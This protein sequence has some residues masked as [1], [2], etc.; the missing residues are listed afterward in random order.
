MSRWRPLERW[1]LTEHRRLESN[2]VRSR[3]DPELV[4]EHTT[5]AAH[6][7]QSI[8][9][10]AGPVERQHELRPEP[11]TKG[12]LT[13]QRLELGG[14]DHVLTERQAGV[15]EILDRTEPEILEARRLG[16]RP[17]CLPELGERRS[18]PT[19]ERSAEPASD[20]IRVRLIRPGDLVQRLLEAECVE[21]IGANVEHV[22]AVRRAHG[23]RTDR[24]S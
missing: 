9:L 10:A 1:L 5:Q 12:M 15:D 13:D 21:P 18:A 6:G 11:L 7:V 19:L 23:L 20:P 22:A 17:S 24:P 14:Q 16:H 3:L 2:D 8:R 4:A